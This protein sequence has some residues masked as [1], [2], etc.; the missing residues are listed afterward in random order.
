MAKSNRKELSSYDEKVDNALI[1]GPSEGLWGN[2]YRGF[3][4]DGSAKI[5]RYCF[6]DQDHDVQRNKTKAIHRDSM[7]EIEEN[8]NIIF[9]EIPYLNI[10]LDEITPEIWNKFLN[11]NW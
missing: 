10:A 7:A 2:G 9:E 1:P 11:K 5:V 3:N 4:K 6:I 8:A